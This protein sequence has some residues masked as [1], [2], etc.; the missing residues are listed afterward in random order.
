MP[1]MAILH[2]YQPPVKPDKIVHT[3]LTLEFC[4]ETM[5][6]I[7]RPSWDEWDYGGDINVLRDEC[8]PL[9][10]EM[11]LFYAAYAKKG[12]DGYYHIIPSMEPEKWGWYGGLAR[13]K[14]VIS[15]LCMFRWALNRAGGGGG[16]PRRGLR[17]CA[18]SGGK[19]P[20]TSRPTR[21][22]TRPRARCSAPSKA[23]NRSTWTPITSAKRRNTRPFSRTKSTSILRKNRRR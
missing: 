12:D 2:G 8:Y 18:A 15:S 16:D 17:T 14:D 6:Q 20:A 3:T 7:I 22:G 9:M 21:P 10:R 23:S 4:L 1:G 11:A 19:S 13:N 5:A